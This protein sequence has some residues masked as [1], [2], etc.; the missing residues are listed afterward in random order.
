MSFKFKG[1]FRFRIKLSVN[2]QACFWVWPVFIG[3]SGDK[4]SLRSELWNLFFLS[5]FRLRNKRLETQHLSSS[6]QGN[7]YQSVS[8]GE[9]DVLL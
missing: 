7:C 8:Q 1:S 9:L 4:N 6:P 5:W 2:L 3:P